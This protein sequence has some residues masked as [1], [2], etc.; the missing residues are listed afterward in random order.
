MMIVKIT[1]IYSW[2]YLLFFFFKLR[3][4]TTTAIMIIHTIRMAIRTIT[5]N[6]TADMNMNMII[7]YTLW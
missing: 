5:M 3:M 6:I 4:I 1:I 2:S 7:K